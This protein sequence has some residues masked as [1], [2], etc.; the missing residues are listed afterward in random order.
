MFHVEQ[1]GAGCP[2]C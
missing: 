1:V 2:K